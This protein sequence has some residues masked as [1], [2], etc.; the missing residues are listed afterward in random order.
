[1]HRLAIFGMLSGSLA[2]GQIATV[3][4]GF[5]GTWALSPQ[6]SNTSP[7]VK[8]VGGSLDIAS[9]SDRIKITSQIVTSEH[10]SLQ[11]AFDLSLDGNGQRASFKRIDDTAFDVIVS[12][13]SKKLGKHVEESHFVLSTDGDVLTETISE[14]DPVVRTSLILVF[15]KL[16]FIPPAGPVFLRLV[17]PAP[18]VLIE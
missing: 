9:V 11:Q 10:E 2:F 17:A 5:E 7:R 12:V 13:N 1:M 16:L 4:T 6:D 14:A 18:R 3:P 8:I 15:H